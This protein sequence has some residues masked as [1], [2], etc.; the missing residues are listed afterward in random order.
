MELNLSFF[1]DDAFH[2]FRSYRQV[3]GVLKLDIVTH[4]YAV[5]GHGLSVQVIQPDVLVAVF[6]LGF[7]GTPWLSNVNI[8]EL[9]GG[10]VNASHFQVKVI[11][12]SLKDTGDLPR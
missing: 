8:T 12:D 9:A 2:V 6:D 1:P 10:A 4:V 3:P 11:L 5:L 7:S